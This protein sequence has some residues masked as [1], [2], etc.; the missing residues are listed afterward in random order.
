MR[1]AKADGRLKGYDRRKCANL[2]MP[3]SRYATAY[4]NR[5]H[6]VNKSYYFVGTDEGVI[7]KCSLNYLNR[8]LDLFLAHDG[9]INEMKFSPFSKK[10]FATCGDDWHTRI[11]ADGK[12]QQIIGIDNLILAD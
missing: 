4:V 11:W 7:H 6:P 5:S 2:S 1:V 10:I 12:V 3:V 8:H 9:C